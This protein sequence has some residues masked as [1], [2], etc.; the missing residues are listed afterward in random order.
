MQYL[1]LSLTS[2]LITFQCGSARR[3]QSRIVNGAEALPGEFPYQI[4][5]NVYGTHDCGGSILNKDYVLTA[6]H[7]IGSNDTSIMK[8]IAGTTNLYELP[9][10]A[11][12][13]NVSEIH[14]HKE[15]D[16]D[17]GWKNDIA[18]LKVKPPFK[19]NKYIAPAKLPIKNAA[20]N[21]GDEA[22][23][24]GFGRIKQG[25]PLSQKLLK[26]QVS[27]ETLEYCQREI[28]GDPVR[29]TNVCIRNATAETGFCNGDSGGPLTVDETVVGIVSFSPNLGCAGFSRKP[30][31]L[32]RV[33]AYIDWIDEQMVKGTKINQ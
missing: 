16:G 4:S 6:A 20:V 30:Q 15:Y 31:V 10:S 8:I 22:V 21:P 3:A 9:E 23:V 29:P 2:A 11:T 13:H 1:V 18:I 25:G 12:T 19:F 27:I 17:D 26:A 24:S 14:V 32:T 7:C 5:L 33:S 28:I